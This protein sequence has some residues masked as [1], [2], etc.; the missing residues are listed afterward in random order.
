MILGWGWGGLDHV[1][2]PAA[3]LQLNLLKNV[4]WGGCVPRRPSHAPKKAV[5]YYSGVNVVDAAEQCFFFHA[6]CGMTVYSRVCNTLHYA[7]FSSCPSGTQLTGHSATGGSKPAV[8]AFL[9]TKRTVKTLV[10]GLGCLSR[11]YRLPLCGHCLGVGGW[12]DQFVN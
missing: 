10:V 4:P 12:Q 6:I 7:T 5:T 2:G 11:L 9:P 8:S 3:H 1:W